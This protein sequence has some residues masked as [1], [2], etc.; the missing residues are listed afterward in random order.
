[1]FPARCGI[2]AQVAT[3]MPF[4]PHHIHTSPTTHYLKKKKKTKHKKTTQFI[5]SGRVSNSFDLM[6]QEEGKNATV[7]ISLSNAL[8]QRD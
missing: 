4:H 1:M 7:F 8:H 6:I 5:N 3:Q 2:N